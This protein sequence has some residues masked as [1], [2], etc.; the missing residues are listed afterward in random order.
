M[1]GHDRED[2]RFGGLG[3]W[4]AAPDGG[5]A[6]GQGAGI[7]DRASAAAGAAERAGFGSIWVTESVDVRPAGVPYE[8]YSLLGAL[9]VTTGRIH[10]GA[11]ADG[12]ER[13]P[14]SILSKIVTGV[15]VISH[16]RAVLSLDGDC[17]DE[18]DPERLYEAMTVC[19]AVLRDDLPT[20]SGRIYTIDGAL[21][22]PRPVQP[23][24]VPI[25]VFVHGSGPG[26]AG[27]LEVGVRWADAVVADGGADGV[28]DAVRV[29]ADHGGGGSAPGAPVE[30]F[31][32]V[33]VGPEGPGATG[34]EV[35]DVRAA[36]ATGCIV[37]ISYPWETA[38][39]EELSSAW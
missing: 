33:G 39:A 11:V 20:Y 13:R 18:A 31:G 28:R 23:G 2:A 34:G 36:G 16:G 27:L 22:R 5:D 8:A 6:T 37:R 9:A 19:R 3:L 17:A 4:L 7:L 14:P 30:V 15:D 21:N 26:R 1:V 29:A 24:G 35:H 25:V 10:L 38:T 32:I 12:V